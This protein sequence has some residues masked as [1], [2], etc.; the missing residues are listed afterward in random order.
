MLVM[1]FPREPSV[2]HLQLPAADR[3]L[4]AQ[5]LPAAAV[6]SVSIMGLCFASTV[7]HAW[8]HSAS[9]VK[10][11]VPH[12]LSSLCLMHGVHPAWGSPGSSLSFKKPL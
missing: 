9:C 6:S 11:T 8:I 5:L 10:L 1:T 3:F 4:V 12:A 7:P 2:F